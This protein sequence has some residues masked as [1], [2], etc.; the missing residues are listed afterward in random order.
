MKRTQYFIGV[1]EFLGIWRIKDGKSLYYSNMPGR[2]TY[3]IYTPAGWTYSI[4]T[5]AELNYQAG[6]KQITRDEARKIS[7]KAFRKVKA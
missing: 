4:Y 6:I 1:V 5:P 3:S 2:W 7:P